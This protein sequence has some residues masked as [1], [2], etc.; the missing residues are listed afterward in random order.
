MM[1]T[2]RTALFSFVICVLI[3]HAARPCSLVINLGFDSS[4]QGRDIV[5]AGVR[6]AA[7]MWQAVLADPVTP[8]IEVR[9]RQYGKPA[10]TS[11]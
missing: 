1:K 2:I 4:L 8:D 10:L 9:E 3:T 7:D 11:P 5:Q 6:K